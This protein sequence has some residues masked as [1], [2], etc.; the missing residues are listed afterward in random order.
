MEWLEAVAGTPWF[1]LLIF[2][3]RLTDVS[4]GTLRIILISRGNRTW[5][6]VIGFVESGVWLLAISQVF[7]HLDR[8]TSYFAYAGGFAAGT[9][10]GVTLEKKI[11]LGLVS[12][13]IITREDATRLAE[14]LR[15]ER[16]GVTMLGARGLHG[17][18]RLIFCI[19]K[20]REMDRLLEIV[21]EVD[22]KAFVSVSDVRTAEEGYLPGSSRSGFWGRLV[23]RK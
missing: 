10:L 5:A 13:R 8:P 2:C 1:P 18:V 6:T 4:L 17:R 22:P 15:E 7:A 20:R 23:R 11:A 14:S 19:V 3:A 12:V 9:W 16:F 21:R